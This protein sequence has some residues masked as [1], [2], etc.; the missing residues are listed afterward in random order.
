M[1]IGEY[2]AWQNLEVT[3]QT[4]CPREYWGS[5]TILTSHSGWKCLYVRLP[6]LSD[7][8][9]ATEYAYAPESMKNKTSLTP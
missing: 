6:I 9:T 7:F 5:E 3:K 2:R 4:V 1:D 8:T